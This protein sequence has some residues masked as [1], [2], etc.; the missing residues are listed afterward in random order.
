[1][2]DESK[3]NKSVASGEKTGAEKA[4]GKKEKRPAKKGK[5]GTAFMNQVEGF[6]NG[7][8]PLLITIILAFFVMILACLAVFF[9]SVRGAEK[10]MVPN[11]VGKSWTTALLEMQER[12]LYPKISLRYSE[13]PGD[14]GTILAQNPSGG[15]IV[16]AQQRI[17]LT[18]SRGIATDSL[19]EYTGKQIDSVFSRLNVLFAGP[20]ALVKVAPVA[21]QKDSSP[22]G[23]VL[24][25]YPKAGT[26]ISERMTLHL[27]VSSGDA[28]LTTTVPEITGM[29]VAQVLNTMKT[30]SVI[31]DFTSRE[32]AEGEKGGVVVS[33]EKKGE[34]K[35][36]MYQRIKAE[37]AFPAPKE[38]DTTVTGIFTHKLSEYPYP[39]P[40]TLECS[41]AEGNVSVVV[42]FSHPGGNLTIPYTVKKDST[43]TL[44]VR[45]KVITNKTL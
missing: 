25:Q 24:A 40:V 21:Y 3:V 14:E 38:T 34:E 1:M 37:F 20:S 19:E 6:S 16:K 10:V 42:D 5:F 27:V 9:A 33:V 44:K 22:A 12:E 28:V 23:T 41:D 13:V 2:S 35:V 17:S 8:L 31:F 11:L 43:L 45:G 15:A 26:T 32:S 36:P 7:G 39:V 29:S 30:A 4:A 18:V